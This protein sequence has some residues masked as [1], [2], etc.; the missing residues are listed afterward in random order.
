MTV[1]VKIYS[2]KPPDAQ[3]Y[4]QIGKDTDDKIWEL[5]DW[6]ATQP[7]FIRHETIITE[8]HERLYTVVWETVEDYANWLESRVNLLGHAERVDHNIQYGI[9]TRI[10]ESIT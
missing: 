4:G 9:T 2:T 5:H 1:T 8:R 3:F 7:G 10:E 6:T